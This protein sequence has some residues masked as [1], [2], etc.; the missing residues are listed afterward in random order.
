MAEKAFN[1]FAE[2]GIP[3]AFVSYLK[4]PTGYQA[5]FR[6]QVSFRNLHVEKKVI[7]LWLKNPSKN[8]I[9]W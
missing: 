2:A 1:G 5:V 4:I 9:D 6:V 8:K 3:G 7:Y